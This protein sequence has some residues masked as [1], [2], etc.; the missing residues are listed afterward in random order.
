[1]NRK[2]LLIALFAAFAPLSCIAEPSTPAQGAALTN[3][4]DQLCR[5]S[6]MLR[7]HDL[8]NPQGQKDSDVAY[9]A[10]ADFL[11]EGQLRKYTLRFDSKFRVRYFMPEH[12]YLGD[13]SLG[14]DT[15]KQPRLRQRIIRSA[16]TFKR[17]IGWKSALGPYVQRVGSD[18]IVTFETVTSEQQKRANYEYLDPYVS[19]LVTPK[20]TVFGGF[21]GA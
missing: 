13:T 12:F 18:F 11:V 8:R 15:V 4:V 14:V 6:G 2:L 7:R 9:I 19:F 1:M 21:W 5:W 3:A 20:G 17:Q 10:I 16:A